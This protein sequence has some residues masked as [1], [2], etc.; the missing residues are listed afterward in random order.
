MDF[1][2]DDAARERLE[3]LR[4]FGR[5]TIRP[6]GIE[7]DRAGSPTPPDH[8]FFR[9]VL[10]RGLTRPPAGSDEGGTS[11]GAAV[12]RV[13]AGQELAYW[14]RGVSSSLPGPGLG[15]GPV[16]SMGTPEQ[17][18]RLLGP[19]RDMTEPRW[20]AFAMTEPGAG[21][22]VAR[23][24]SRAVR[25]G[26]DWVLNGAKLYSA[27][28]DRADWIV[29]FATVDPA[30]GRAGHR[31]FIVERGMPG[32]SEPKPE[33]KMGIKAYASASFTMN[34]LRVPADNLLGSEARYESRGG[35]QRPGAGF[36]GAMQTF[37]ATRPAIAAN[38]VGMARACLDE[39]TAFARDRDRLTGRHRDRLERMRRRIRAAWLMC[40]KAAWLADRGEPNMVEASMSK[41]TA[42]EVAMEAASLGME[43]LG[44]VGAQGEHLIEKLYRDVKAMDIVE[45]TGQIQRIVMARHLV[46][47]PRDA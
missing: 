12:W 4:A 26:D 35:G 9:E 11:L 2:L 34:D 15:G 43:V 21:S 8:P 30:L 24:Q 38:A 20:A 22:D 10:A 1:Q 36:K 19:F 29:V 27:N 33:K 18:K 37:N 5:E 45:G 44:A 41:A 32:L 23:I 13:V 25:D 6:L 40:L 17:Q 3:A 16:M 42:A 46:N 31:A 7:R 47:Y 14:D 39:A 28:A